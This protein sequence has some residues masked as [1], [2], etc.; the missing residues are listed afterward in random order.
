MQIRLCKH[1]LKHTLMLTS[2]DTSHTWG[3]AAYCCKIGKGQEL[4]QCLQNYISTSTFADVSYSMADV[5][6]KFFAYKYTEHQPML[7]NTVLQMLLSQYKDTILS[8]RKSHSG[9]KMV[10]T[11]YLL[12]GSLIHMELLIENR[13][14][15]HLYKGIISY[16]GKTAFLY[17]NGSYDTRI[18]YKLW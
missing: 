2:I 4:S 15:Q 9:D 6:A 18:Q 13:L 5:E 8:V 10:I 16:M 12:N 11:S 3:M 7:I 17:Q 1:K 14:E